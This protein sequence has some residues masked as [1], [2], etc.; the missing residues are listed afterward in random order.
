MDASLTGMPYTKIATASE[1][2]SP[3]RA[4]QWALT[5]KNARQPR[6]TTTGKA[7]TSADNPTLPATGV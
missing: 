3:A 5:R 6:S 2:A 1:V 7:A 4:A